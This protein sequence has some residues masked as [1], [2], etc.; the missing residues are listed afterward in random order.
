MGLWHMREG[1]PWLK[2]L[3]RVGARRLQQES[4]AAVKAYLA[5]V[6]GFLPLEGK[7]R[8]WLSHETHRDLETQVLRKLVEQM[9]DLTAAE[10]AALAPLRQKK[11]IADLQYQKLASSLRAAEADFAAAGAKLKLLEAGTQGFGTRAVSCTS[12]RAHDCPFSRGR[13]SQ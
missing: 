10:L 3:E 12:G 5:Q 1:T 8:V 4:D 9:K 2:L 11:E 6:D 13:S 7:S